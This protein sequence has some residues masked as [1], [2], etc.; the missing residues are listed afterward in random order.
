M[1]PDGVVRGQHRD[2]DRLVKVE[3]TLGAEGA[4]FVLSLFE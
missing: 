3:L 2:R 1:N 4:K